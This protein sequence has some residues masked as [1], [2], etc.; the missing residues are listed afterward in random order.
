MLVDNVLDEEEQEELLMLLADFS[1][2]ST[3]QHQADLAS[4]LPLC[5]PAPKVEFPSMKFC[6]TGKFAYGPRKICEEIVK[7]LGGKPVSTI[8][9]KADYLVIDTFCST[10][11]I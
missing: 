3:V 10:D 11:W 1:G 8:T 7:D 6:L 4:G 2:E 9:L 5:L